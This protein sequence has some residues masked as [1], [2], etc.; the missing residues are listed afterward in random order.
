MALTT[1]LAVLPLVAGALCGAVTVV[2][3]VRF[4]LY[5]RRVRLP[6]SLLMLAAGLWATGYGLRL[7]ADS[8]ATKVFL[9]HVSWVGAVFVPTLWFAFTLAYTGEERLLNHRGVAALVVEPVLV[10]T[11]LV[12]GSGGVLVGDHALA[13]VPGGVVLTTRYGPAYGLHLL[14]TAAVGLAGA[15]MMGRLL[16]RGN[17]AYSKGAFALL[18]AASAPLFAFGLT[19]LGLWP[20]WFDPTPATFGVSAVV[21]LVALR[22]DGL[23]DVT[24]VARDFVFSQMRDGIVVLDDRGR[25][26]EVNPAAAPLFTVD[27]SEAVGSYV[28]DVCYNPLGMQALLADEREVLEVTVDTEEGRR[29]FEAAATRLGGDSGHERGW[30][31]LFRDVTDYRQTEEQF[32]ALIENSRDLITIIDRAGRRKY[33]SPSASHVLGVE[34]EELVGENSFDRM[35]PDDRDDARD[36]MEEIA[37]TDEAVRTQIRSRHADGTWRTLDV[38]CVNLLDDPAV[39]GI[40]VNARDVTD[41]TSYQQRLR[42]LNRVLRH[43]LRNDMN[44]ILGHADLLMDEIDESS[45]HHA[46][47]IRRKGESLVELGKRAREIDRTLDVTN[48]TRKPVEVTE[49]LGEQ[50][51]SLAETHPGVVVNRHLPDEAWVKATAHVTMAISNVV[52]NAVEH[53]DRALPRIGVAVSKPREDVVEVRVVD[54]G[55]GI[56]D[57]ELD[58]LQSGRETQLQHVSG[59]GLWLVKWVLTGSDGSVSFENHSPRGTAVVMRF[60]AADPAREESNASASDGDAVEGRS[61]GGRAS[62]DGVGER[63]SANDRPSEG[64]AVAAE[65]DD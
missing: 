32:R 51:D 22:G 33:V 1:Q 15:V 45:A 31:V 59:L 49:P 26:V 56:P 20:H 4:R 21:V 54:N 62:D 60:A 23:F 46:R 63:R 38:V 5:S 41:R 14:Y 28:A 44:V 8:L 9:Y 37:N 25:V 40:V 24:P 55:P 34:A 43:D 16:V 3:L 35:H 19:L 10:L 30:T 57:S 12:V 18:F 29:H 48:R 64:D 65:N 6:F 2:V 42:V 36:V 52:E 17:G 39:G 11:L 58:A 47:T 7:A 13:S 53:N 61:A 50:L 27:R